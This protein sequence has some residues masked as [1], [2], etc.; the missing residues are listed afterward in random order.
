MAP[1]P[2]IQTSDRGSDATD[3]ERRFGR[4]GSPSRGFG[5]RRPI[6]VKLYV[7][8]Q[9]VRFKIRFYGVSFWRVKAANNVAE[10][11]AA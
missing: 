7:E 8:N 3:G 5:R 4:H 2:A 10:P 1:P 9:L 6:G 11:L